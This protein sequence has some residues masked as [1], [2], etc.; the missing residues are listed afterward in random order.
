MIKLRKDVVE[1][2]NYTQEQWLSTCSPQVSGVS[3]PWESQ[4][5]PG[6]YA[7]LPSQ[8][9]QSGD[10]KL[11]PGQVPAATPPPCGPDGSFS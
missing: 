7:D 4:E 2:I 9:L 5:V 6:S 11:T 10:W 3:V 8:E 1:E